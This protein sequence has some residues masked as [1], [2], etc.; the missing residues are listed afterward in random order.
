MASQGWKETPGVKTDNILMEGRDQKGWKGTLTGR[1]GRKQREVDS[2]VDIPRPTLKQHRLM[3]RKNFKFHCRQDAIMVCCH[4]SV[5]LRDNICFRNYKRKCIDINFA[6]YASCIA[7]GGY[8]SD[9]RF[10]DLFFLVYK[11]V[12]VLFTT[13]SIDISCIAR[14]LILSSL[15]RQHRLYVL[16]CR[17][18]I[19]A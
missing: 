15:K 16:D 3:I 8:I 1:Y 2:I 6:I 9:C 18:S 10:E 4:N 11:L 19:P 14:A 12:V 5:Y 7:R 13:L 17:V